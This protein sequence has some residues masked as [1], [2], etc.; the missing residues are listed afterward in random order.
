MKKQK[1]PEISYKKT[2]VDQ[3]S[4]HLKY[5]ITGTT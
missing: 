3:N 5:L 1:N 4:T 2:Y